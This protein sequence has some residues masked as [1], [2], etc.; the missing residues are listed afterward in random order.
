M[1]YR[2]HVR[3]DFG[4]KDNNEYQKLIAAFLQAGWVY[5][6]T[7]AV[8]TE[9]DDF[10]VVRRGLDILARQLPYAGTISALMFDVQRSDDFGGQFYV[11]ADNHPSALVDVRAR[12]SPP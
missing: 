6:E 10:D 5:V 4:E 9:T 12:P 11:A 3:L 1:P 8:A 2:A 7:S